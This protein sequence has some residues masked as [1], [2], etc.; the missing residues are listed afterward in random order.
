[1][2]KAVAAE[3]KKSGFTILELAVVVIVVTILSMI[4][5][6]SFTQAIEKSRTAEAKRILGQ[7]RQLERA[8][9]MNTG[10]YTTEMDLVGEDAPIACVA[11][12]YFS[13]SIGAASGVDFT[14]V[15]SRCSVAGGKNPTGPD[16]TITVDADGSWSGSAGYY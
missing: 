5:V 3:K 6:V 4:G 2:L 16:Y 13:Y 14:A 15:A 11:T 8:Y 7:I 9:F 12:H 1:M 10:A